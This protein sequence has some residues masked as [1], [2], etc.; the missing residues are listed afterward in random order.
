MARYAF[1]WHALRDHWE[2]R[3]VIAPSEAPD[4]ELTVLTAEEARTVLLALEDR[5]PPPWWVVG[6]MTAETWTEVAHRV[7][8]WHFT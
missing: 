2:L 3:A 6:E 8:T 7:R 4:D 5:C 1:A